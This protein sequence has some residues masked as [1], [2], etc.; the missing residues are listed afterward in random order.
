M[1]APDFG[2]F[3]TAF[4]VR[5][6]VIE[7]LY[8]DYLAQYEEDDEYCPDFEGYLVDQF[9]THAYLQAAL[10]GGGIIECLEACDAVYSS[11]GFNA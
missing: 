1:S 3:A 2:I 6:S 11:F 10:E 9:A 4:N 8:E 7:N 5:E